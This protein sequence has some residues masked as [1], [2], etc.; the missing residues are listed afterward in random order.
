VQGTDTTIAIAANILHVSAAAEA[1]QV[2][3][4]NRSRRCESVYKVKAV[5]YYALRREVSHCFLVFFLFCFRW[6]LMG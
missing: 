5:V 4:F 1:L 6:L 2:E 3:R